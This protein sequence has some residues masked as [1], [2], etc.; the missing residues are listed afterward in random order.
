MGVCPLRTLPL[1]REY[2]SL[3]RESR[4]F[5][6]KSKGAVHTVARL[7][8]LQTRTL[9][10]LRG[11]GQELFIV[12]LL[13]TR[14]TICLGF[15]CRKNTRL[16]LFEDGA[17]RK[18]QRERCSSL[19]SS[20]TDIVENSSS[21]SNN[22]FGSSNSFSNKETAQY[23][24]KVGPDMEAFSNGFY[25]VKEEIPFE[26]VTSESIVGNIPNDLKGTYYKVGPAMFTAGSLPS[27]AARKQK[28]EISDGQ[29]INRMVKHPFDADGAI[30]AM[31]FGNQETGADTT[32]DIDIT[33]RYRYIRTV[34]FERERK[35][36]S[37]L[38]NAMDQTRTESI[39]T[40]DSV[41]NDY[42]LPL[43]RHHLQ[44]GLNKQR[45]NTANTRVVHWGQK[46]ISFWDGG[47]PYKLCSLSLSTEGKSQLG[48]LPPDASICSKS[49]YDAQ[50]KRMAFYGTSYNNVGGS[51]ISI[52][53][54][55]SRFRLVATQQD[56]AVAPQEWN[57]PGY[58]LINDGFA[59]TSPSWYVFIQPPVVMNQLQFMIGKDPSKSLSIDYTAPAVV[60]LM[61]RRTVDTGV[62]AKNNE[63]ISYTIPLDKYGPETNVQIINAFEQ[64]EEDGSTSVYMD[65]LRSYPNT[66]NTKGKNMKK[67]TNS[68]PWMKTLEEY[69]SSSTKK[70]I[71]R[72]RISNVTNNGENKGAVTK[73]CLCEVQSYFATVNPAVSGLR[74]RFIYASVG[75]LGTEI[76]PPQGIMKFDCENENTEVGSASVVFFPNSC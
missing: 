72:Y 2:L 70:S 36:S 42:P 71:W 45:K 67:Q 23:A 25:T 74:N 47:L 30:F 52:Y 9:T 32:D 76:A 57:I 5:Y 41:N 15:T 44:P 26:K 34:A 3:S 62:I 56:E 14:A 69:A 17:V 27:P 13:F 18:K 68:W 7:Q 38:Y 51:T 66:E 60:Y 19:P 20:P 48:V 35:K 63:M 6:L 24:A 58:A 59:L 65:L 37:R 64:K 4:G 40:G 10:M 53:E 49:A 28:L 12:A 43:L 31:T 22:N 75:S 1:H 29:D 16:C 39:G 55:N 73:K 8:R 50:N 21:S 33:Y 61:P 11:R 54:F 46:L